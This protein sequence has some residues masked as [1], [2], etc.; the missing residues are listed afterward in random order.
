MESMTEEELEALQDRFEEM[1]KETENAPPD[2]LALEVTERFR[3]KGFSVEQAKLNLVW[4]NPHI[5][6]ICAKMPNMT[7]L[8]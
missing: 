8:F 5:A 1:M 2:Q 3:N 4:E 6:S 7:L